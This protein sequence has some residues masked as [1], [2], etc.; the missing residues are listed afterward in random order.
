M[1]DRA[2]RIEWRRL[3]LQTIRFQN[4]KTCS[5]MFVVFTLGVLQHVMFLL[6]I[7][8]RQVYRFM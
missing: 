8:E 5:S 1:T 3:A 4:G 7:P 2:C 6:V